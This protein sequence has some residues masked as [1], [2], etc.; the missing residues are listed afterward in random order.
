MRTVVSGP[1]GGN[2][3][4]LQKQIELQQ[5]QLRSLDQERA[6]L[7]TQV[8]QVSGERATLKAQV[9][10]LSAD[11]AA[12]TAQVDKLSGDLAKLH[13]E[14]PRFQVD[15]VATSFKTLL[16]TV[17]APTVTASPSGVQ[18][19]LQSI[20]L[21]IKGFVDVQGDKM[22]VTVPKPGDTIDA[23]SLS[24][25]KLSFVTVPTLPPPKT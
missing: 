9:D 7:K 12:L 5:T 1:G 20:E 2:L 15:N 10:H 4:D 21:E 19:T 25:V 3:E 23:N 17:Q 11:R 14:R 18:G 24:L 6:A 16:E 13:A 22:Q 8:D